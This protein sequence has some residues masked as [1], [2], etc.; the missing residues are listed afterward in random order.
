MDRFLFILMVVCMPLFPVHAQRQS[1][2]SISFS[3]L[4]LENGLSQS[5]VDDI[6]QDEQGNLWFATHNGLNK[7][8]GYD[9]TVYQHDTQNP[10]SIGNDVVRSC[11]IDGRNRLWAGNNEGV[12]LYDA[13]T[14]RFRNFT[15]HEDGHY[16]SVDDIVQLDEHRLL[17]CV[18][19]N[20][21]LL[22]DAD[23]LKLCP[24]PTVF[25]G[26]PAPTKLYRKDTRLYIAT[27]EGLYAYSDR[28]K[29]VERL[30]GDV[31]G[32][33]PI[34]ALLQ[35]GQHLW[36]GTEGKGLFR[37]DL[38]TGAAKCYTR[39]R[40]NPRSICSNYI[41][42]LCLDA[43]NRLW[44]GTLHGLS[45]YN[46]QHDDFDVY[47]NDPLLENS[48]SQ[49]SVRDI[50]MDSQGG[51][52]LGTYF[53]G[54]NYY[55]PL[56]SRFTNL[57]PLP[58]EN[59]LNCGII[60]PICQDRDG[61]FWIGTNGGG[62]NFYNPAE[63]T[64]RHYTIRQGL[65]A[66]DIKALYLD[67]N[68]RRVY[69]GTHTGGL[70]ILDIQ[71]GHIRTIG[72]AD[73][74][75]TLEP[76]LTGEFW[77]SSIA[78]LLRFNPRTQT[79]ARVERQAD[80]TPLRRYRITDMVR[81]SKQ[82]LWCIGEDGLDVYVERD[83]TLQHCPLLA[84]SLSLRHT[85][86][87]CVY[88]TRKGGTFYIGTADGLWRLDEDSGQ[89]EQYTTRHGLPNNMV[90]GILEDAYGDL[91]LSTDN[92]LSHFYVGTGKFRNYTDK[93]G[94]QSKQFTNKAYCRARNGQMLFGG[95]NGIT[96]FR[97]EDL[98]DNPYVPGVVLSRL[99]LF[100]RQVH[101][102][103]EAG[104][105]EKSLGETKRI[106]LEAW[107]SAFS[108]E[109]GVPN[110][111]AGGQ[112]TFAYMLEGYDRDWYYTKGSRTAAYSNLP[113]GTYR[114]LVKAANNDGKWNDTPTVLEVEVLPV[115]Y[116]TWWAVLLFFAVFAAMA[117][118]VIR[119]FWMR[120]Q[121]EARLQLERKDKERQH[122][123]NEMKL[124]FF[125]NISHELRTPLT[126]I[127]APL[128]DILQKVDDRWL[129]KELEHIRRNT[130]RLLHLVNQLMDYRR[131]ELGVFALKVRKN[132]IHQTIEK[133]FVFYEKVAQH[134]RIDY[135][136]RS[137]VE[138]KE[139]LCDPDYL[140]LIVNNLI[141]N[142]FKYTGEGKSVTLT[143][144][145]GNGILLLQVADTG[146]GI[147]PDKQGRIFER[148][149]QGDNEHIGSGVGL[150]LVQRLVELHHG[151]IELDSA[152]GKGSTFTV[153]IPTVP[154]AYT[155]GELSSS[156]KE[157][158]TTN[159]REMYVLDA[160]SLD[161]PADAGPDAVGEENAAVGEEKAG[162]EK[163]LI[164]E[165]NAEIRRYLCDELGKNYCMLHAGNGAEALDVMKANPEIDLV[166]TDV[167]MPVM[168]GLQLCK[169]IKQNLGTCHIP[170]I[171]LSAKTEPVEQLE[172]LQMGA[173]DYIPKPFPMPLVR[174]K[175]RNLF[176]TRRRVIDRY[177]N[178]L[179]V[180]P[181]KLALNPLDEDFLKRAVEV[182]E[183]HLDDVDFNNDVF[184]R[185][186][187]MSRSNLHLKLK[188]LTGESVGDFIRKM[189][190]NRAGKLL[191]EGRYT[192][193]EISV[194]VGF[195]TP[196]YFTTSFKK[197]FGCLPSE[198]GKN[199]Q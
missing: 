34:Y 88:E 44:V 198:Y 76:T 152:E 91:W 20:R 102:G 79:F 147:P 72:K 192:V 47:A 149:Y 175:I 81:D 93:D 135:N 195:N 37:L 187:C 130:N 186:M 92:G 107:Q 106:T 141:S 171:I 24:L 134:K 154:S 29:T 1:A 173:D 84:D 62:L 157:R 11:F 185:E 40:H 190:F 18:P 59:A 120:K 9:F 160:E 143:L 21:L 53:G 96:L 99:N 69:I 165:D 30:A 32:A 46:E 138:G 168:D 58:R 19:A 196:S 33:T 50:F 101:P 75:Y 77:V 80:G 191:K 114:F 113:H 176:R 48:L 98:S 26:L 121:M 115:W 3:H 90:H 178:S 25:A 67:E 156:D 139:V 181:E 6:A 14:D 177:S 5:T 169:R 150:S 52:W 54:I 100:N 89:L 117:V 188:A 144:K 86:T 126:M 31:L 60:G 38:R 42:A 66:D 162:A 123:M 179:E 193:A 112:N 36:V 13:G 45:I 83:G 104:I 105:L 74:I 128:Q 17:F 16:L 166:L 57:R 27:G 182:V 95:V 145:E 140:D 125:I 172:G 153:S 159:S 109:F 61:N 41:R 161:A 78:E 15:F 183:K 137:E 180:E 51:I 2:I 22:F 8:D 103:D 199:E 87:N 174:T 23:S 63:Q 118:G 55:H 170:V 73:N 133:D 111:L 4:G 131:A 7:F 189:R 136:F 158:H 129:R 122:E 132:F 39:D 10:A 49:N 71:T 94:L 184:A 197:F 64:F 116:E 70:S 155:A 85:M 68:S 163:I 108:L 119:Y 43:Q 65:G 127:L 142:A 35:V 167:M 82:R 56:G 146:D 194:M 151:H 28:T 148:F 124:R 12:S 110:Y 164:V 97:A